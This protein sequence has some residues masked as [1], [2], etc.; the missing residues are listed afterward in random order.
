VRTGDTEIGRGILEAKLPAWGG[1]A[2]AIIMQAAATWLLA[3]LAPYF[4]PDRFPMLYILSAMLV[5]YLFGEGPALLSIAVGLIAFDYFFVPPMRALWPIPTRTEELEGLIE[6]LAG[7]LILAF[8]ALLMRRSRFR[9]QQLADELERQRSLMETLLQNIPVGIGFHDR[10]TRHVIANS[11]LAEMSRTTLDGMLGKTVW[12]V[13]PPDLA[14]AAAEDIHKIFAT[15]EPTVWTNLTL[16]MEGDRHFDVQHM[17]VLTREGEII[18]VGV[19]VVETTEQVKARE[20]LERLYAHEHQVA[21]ALQTSLL[22][23]VPERIDCFGFETLYRAALEEARVG[24]DFY[25]VFRIA[26][27]RIGI[28]IGDVSGKGLK[29]AV[30]VAMAKYSLRSRAYDLGSPSVVMKEVNRTLQ[31]DM[32]TESFVTVFFGI[33]DCTTRTLT[34]T[35]AGHWPAMLWSA[36][37][38]RASCLG[39]TGPLVGPVPDAVYEDESCEVH[40]GDEIL[41]GTDGLFELPC[42]SESLGIEGLLDLYAESKRSGAGSAGELVDRVTTFCHGELRDDVAILRVFIP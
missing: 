42:K 35:N 18:G 2:I 21:E 15:G 17:P 16:D 8:A 27:D 38:A 30:Q 41:L 39:P 1:Y 13:L 11:T 9:V 14:A 26:D 33:L 32:D 10:A 22:G 40:P 25:D 3:V 24:G 4:P 6:L 23:E 36:V 20:E 5:A 28:A 29:A 34:Y 7:S 12:E 37:E 19:V 31:R